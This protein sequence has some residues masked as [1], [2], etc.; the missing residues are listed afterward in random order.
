MIG[1]DKSIPE[2][3]ICME[4]MTAQ[5]Q[6]YSCKDGHEVCGTCRPR[7]T[8][9]ATCRDSQGYI[10]RNITAEKMVRALLAE[11][12]KTN[13][14]SVWEDSDGMIDDD[15]DSDD[16]LQNKIVFLESEVSSM[17][18]ARKKDSQEHLAKITIMEDKFKKKIQQEADMRKEFASLIEKKIRLDM[19]KK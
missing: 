14:T 8:A 16:E 11:D 19:R 6:I 2:C 4:T 18:E 7:M 9:C 10:C 3:P 17:N 5:T 1:D 12:T 13:V 15:G